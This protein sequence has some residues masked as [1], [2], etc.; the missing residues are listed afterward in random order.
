MYRRTVGLL[1]IVVSVPALGD[2]IIFDV[3]HYDDAVQR[4][5]YAVEKLGADPNGGIEDGD[6]RDTPLCMAPTVGIAEEL[7]RL[8]AIVRGRG[9]ES[10]TLFQCAIDHGRDPNLMGWLRDELG[11]DIDQP[12]KDGMTPLCIA[13][14]HRSAAEVTALLDNGADPTATSRHPNDPSTERDPLACA[15]TNSRPWS[16]VIQIIEV[17]ES[18]GSAAPEASETTDGVLPGA[19][20]LVMAYAIIV[21]HIVSPLFGGMGFYTPPDALDDAPVLPPEPAHI[22]RPPPALP[23]PTVRFPEV[24]ASTQ[25]ESI[26]VDRARSTGRS[27]RQASQ[28][29][30]S[31]ENDLS[32]KGVVMGYTGSPFAPTAR[33]RQRSPSTL[34]HLWSPAR[35]SWRH[36][37]ATNRRKM[38]QST[39]PS[40]ATP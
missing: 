38:A 39:W 30:V 19:H 17:L 26:D 5:R 2:S 7:V 31:T 29:V 9:D 34:P 25:V 11:L 1:A 15:L 21:S 22:G 13:A 8:G 23:A 20:P 37:P 28:L 33:A 36:L 18:A 14:E 4:I 24:R 40:S 32:F 12:N 10:L 16:E 3:L 35:S 27:S 6:Q